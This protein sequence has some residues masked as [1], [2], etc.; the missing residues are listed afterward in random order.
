[1]KDD[2]EWKMTLKHQNIESGIF[3]GNTLTAIF[4]IIG[5]YAFMT[6][7]SLGLSFSSVMIGFDGSSDN[8]WVIFCVIYFF[9]ILILAANIFNIENKTRERQDNW[10][11]FN[12]IRT[13]YDELRYLFKQ[14]KE[15]NIP[16][17]R[18][19]LALRAVTWV[20]NVLLCVYNAV[21][22]SSN[23][24]GASN[25]LLVMFMANMFVYL[26][27]YVI[28]KYRSRE[29]LKGRAWLYAGK[30]NNSPQHS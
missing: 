29:Q 14:M 13:V 11:I 16:R 7:F 1:M 20:I 6:I 2:L 26:L 24:S 4:V 8:F 28:M 10:F 27:Y 30:T 17:V 22:A 9:F 12:V 21:N 3:Q 25:Y 23:K 15:K 5:I 19:L 18:P